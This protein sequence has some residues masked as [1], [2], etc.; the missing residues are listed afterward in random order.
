LVYRSVEGKDFVLLERV[1]NQLEYLDTHVRTGK[2]YSYKVGLISSNG[3][4][5]PLSAEYSVKLK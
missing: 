5:Y 2:K 1:D 3:K 4:R